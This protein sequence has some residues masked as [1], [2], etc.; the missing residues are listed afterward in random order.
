MIRIAFQTNDILLICFNKKNLDIRVKYI[1]KIYIKIKKYRKVCRLFMLV[2]CNW[3]GK[4]GK[5]FESIYNYKINSLNIIN[6]I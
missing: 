4:S 5:H 1:Y 6:M 3:S 2:V